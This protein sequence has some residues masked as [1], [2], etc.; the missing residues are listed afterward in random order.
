MATAAAR[1]CREGQRVPGRRQDNACWR[2][3]I[4]GQAITVAINVAALLV[5]AVVGR[6]EPAG[7]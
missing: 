6:G 7:F 4:T 2:G 3:N 1:A 5:G